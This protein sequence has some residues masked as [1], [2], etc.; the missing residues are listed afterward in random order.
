M[1]SALETTVLQFLDYLKI[2]RNVSPH[3]LKSYSSDLDQ[4]IQSLKT[5]GH[6][7]DPAQIDNIIIRS[8]LATLYEG[9]NSKS[10]VARKTSSLRSF[11]KYLHR[12]SYIET[13]PAAQIATPKIPYKLPSCPDISQILRLLETPDAATDEGKRNKAVLETLYGSGIRVS[14]LTTMNL[15]HLDHEGGWIRV[16]GKGKKVRLVPFG[17]KAL[18][19]ISDYLPVRLKSLLEKTKLKQDKEAL[20]LTRKGVRLSTSGVRHIVKKVTKH[21]GLNLPISPHTLRHAFATHLL[22]QGA[23]LRAIQE[24][25]GHASLSTTQRY[26]RVSMERLMEVYDKAHPRA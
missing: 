2:A 26:T 15:E 14:E 12:N 16:F 8:F 7:L 13:N 9:G 20:F 22:N 6:P 10:T 24:L 17:R 4:F 1:S 21:S 18:E 11:F 19:A 5:A 3:T 23:D 25:L